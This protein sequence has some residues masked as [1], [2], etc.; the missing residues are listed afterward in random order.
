MK[1]RWAE[2]EAS[3]YIDQVIRK[4]I[5]GGTQYILLDEEYKEINLKLD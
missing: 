5:S 2:R 1:T 3:V 4:Y